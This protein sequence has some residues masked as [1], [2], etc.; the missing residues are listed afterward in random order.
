MPNL[1][2]FP[3]ATLREENR[4]I[5]PQKPISIIHHINNHIKLLYAYYANFKY[6]KERVKNRSIVEKVDF[7]YV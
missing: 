2:L 7:L 6:S 4:E 5:V 1:N 3:F